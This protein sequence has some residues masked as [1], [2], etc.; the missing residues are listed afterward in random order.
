MQSKKK[1]N[2]ARSQVNISNTN[3]FDLKFRRRDSYWDFSISINSRPA[4]G[5]H[6]NKPYCIQKFSTIIYW[7]DCNL[8]MFLGMISVLQELFLEYIAYSKYWHEVIFLEN[9]V[10]WLSTTIGKKKL[11]YWGSPEIVMASFFLS[12]KRIWKVLL[13]KYLKPHLTMTMTS[14]SQL[15]PQDCSSTWPKAQKKKSA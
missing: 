3:R 13:S 15:Q 2:S 8:L 4:I 6:V 1:K 11:T 12:E 7:A 5:F 9:R 10:H 14:C